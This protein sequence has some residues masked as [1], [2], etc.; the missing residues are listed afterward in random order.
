MQEHTVNKNL[1]GNKHAEVAVLCQ[2]WGDT[3]TLITAHRQY[4]DMLRLDDSNNSN[5]LETPS[6]PTDGRSFA[7]T[8][9]LIQRTATS[10]AIIQSVNQSTYR[11]T[12][13]KTFKCD[14][15]KN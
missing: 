11:S 15:Q 14:Y 6:L 10:N 4:S 7:D 1:H 2:L 9:H 13:G 12:E 5:P 3:E 8:I